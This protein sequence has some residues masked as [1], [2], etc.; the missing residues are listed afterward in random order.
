[1]IHFFCR[2][3]IMSAFILIITPNQIISVS[4]TE[5]LFA[6]MTL[7]IYFTF[8]CLLFI[9]LVD[10]FFPITQPFYYGNYQGRLLRFIYFQNAGLVLLRD[11]LGQSLQE[12]S[13]IC[14]SICSHDFIS[15]ESEAHLTWTLPV[16]VVVWLHRNF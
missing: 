15:F 10:S 1:M 2:L 9:D 11:Y 5:L 4:N 13:R 12:S 8:H 6:R 7:N 3:Q 16:G 14:F